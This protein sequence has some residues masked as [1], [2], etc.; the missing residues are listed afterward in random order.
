MDPEELPYTGICVCRILSLYGDGRNIFTL[1]AMYH[2]VCA[3]H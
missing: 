3:C 2:S 1:P